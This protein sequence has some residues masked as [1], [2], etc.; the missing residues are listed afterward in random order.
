LRVLYSGR[1][2]ARHQS[3][4]MGSVDDAGERL[5]RTSIKTPARRVVAFTGLG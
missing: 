3:G 2:S 1:G 4:G 5:E